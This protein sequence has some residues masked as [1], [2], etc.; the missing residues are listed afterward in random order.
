VAK[1]VRTSL[2]HYIIVILYYCKSTP[3]LYTTFLFTNYTIKMIEVLCSGTPHQV[4]LQ[5]GEAAKEHIGRAMIFYQNLFQKSCKMNWEEVKTFAL[6]YQPYLEENWPKYVAEMQGVA[7]GAEV[8]YEDVL[9][10][11]VRTEIAFGAFNDGCTALSWRGSRTSIL[12]QNW[13]W[14]TEQAENLIC[15]KIK[16]EKGLS[17]QM[18]TEAGIIGKIGLNEKGVGCTLN[19]LKAKGVSFSKLPCHLA[20]RTVMES[21][22]RAAAV[23]TLENA[24]VA[25]ACHILVADASGGTGMECSCE[26]IVKLEMNRDGIVTHTNHFILEHKSSVVEVVAFPDT[27]F[28]LSRINELLNAAKEEQPSQEV[29][30]RFLRDEMEGD[31]AAI[32]RSPG[33]DTLATLFS[34][35]MDLNKRTARVLVGRPVEPTAKMI[36]SP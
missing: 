22:S 11:N 26:D 30:D 14:N 20:L 1:F 17:I 15:L 5:H 28:R 10:L 16:Q 27:I 23:A 19:A 24:G 33:K 29:V 2:T 34:I 6:K 21:V 35:V 9:A 8:T 18:V 13:D 36:L 32:C 3:I 25:S 12:A 7:A 31:G 4:G